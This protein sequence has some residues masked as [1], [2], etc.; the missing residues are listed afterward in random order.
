MPNKITPENC[1]NSSQQTNESHS[2]S[3]RL[4]WPISAL[5]IG[6]AGAGIVALPSA[7][8]RCRE[9]EMAFLDF[10]FIQNFIPA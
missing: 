5:Y 6:R 10:H 8:V 7:V 1:E 4:G 9:L 2:V 3:K